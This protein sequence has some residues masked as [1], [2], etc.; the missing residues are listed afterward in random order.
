MHFCEKEV[1]NAKK[2]IEQV[3]KDLA[4]ANI[5]VNK[6]LR[7]LLVGSPWQYK[8]AD[9]RG[10][11]FYLK[12]NGNYE[13][14][15]SFSEHESEFKHVVW[16]KC[17]DGFTIVGIYL[18]DGTFERRGFVL[19]NYPEIAVYNFELFQFTNTPVIELE[20]FE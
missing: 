18:T 12:E 4:A 16:G 5:T 1:E 10:A 6:L 14:R 15:L 20:D 17:K 7:D 2:F 8:S 9:D 11:N 13:L 3:A 19:E